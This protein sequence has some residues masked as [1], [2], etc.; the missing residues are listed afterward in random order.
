[1]CFFTRDSV[2][3]WLGLFM[4][5]LFFTLTQKKAA[6]PLIDHAEMKGGGGLANLFLCKRL[7]HE[8]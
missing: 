2:T 7:C 1:M 5:L 4:A 6:A 8:I 3:S